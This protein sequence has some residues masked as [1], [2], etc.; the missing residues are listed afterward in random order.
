[1]REASASRRLVSVV[2]S[3][4]VE[5]NQ[6]GGEFYQKRRP[7]PAPWRSPSGR[8]RT[9]VIYSGIL[10]LAAIEYHYADMSRA[11]VLQFCIKFL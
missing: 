7:P 11:V 5:V 3:V 2:L 9:L 1:M 6:K 10:K 8:F 4:I